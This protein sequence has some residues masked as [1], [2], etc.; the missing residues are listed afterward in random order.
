MAR[1]LAAAEE[2]A[3]TG[4]WELDL[5]SGEALWSA[6]MY[7]VLGVAPADGVRTRAELLEHVHPDDRER[8]D[9]MLA[10]AGAA[11]P[12]H[13]LRLV[14]GDGAVRELRAVGR[15]ERDGTGRAARWT[16]AVQDVTD[17]R[18]S[19]RERHARQLGPRTLSE[20]EIEVLRLA[21]E[22][23]SGPA[24]AE[25]LVLSPATVKT[26]FEHIYEKLGVGDR[27]AAVAYALRS[28]LIH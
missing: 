5:E 17:Q 14:R 1:L 6:G 23:A 19:E 13:T 3:R 21:A 11:A 28:G 24:I 8:V 12:E 20:R 27:A 25:Q 2:L 9:Q 18:R 26:H 4:S 10:G 15:F 7:R 22:G 16:G